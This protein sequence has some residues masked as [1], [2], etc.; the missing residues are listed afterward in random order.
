MGG[1]DDGEL[2][3]G[4][5]LEIFNMKAFIKPPGGLSF[6]V[7]NN[8]KSLKNLIRYGVGPIMKRNNLDLVEIEIFYNWDNRYGR[9]DRI[10]RINIRDI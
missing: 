8:Y 2:I 5:L 7:T 10:M 3:A 9:P 6:A 1:L 4:E